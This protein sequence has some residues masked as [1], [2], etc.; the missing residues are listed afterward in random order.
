MNP[1]VLFCHSSS[2]G[3]LNITSNPPGRRRFGRPPSCSSSLELRRLLDLSTSRLSDRH[4]S[5]VDPYLV[6][7]DTHDSKINFKKFEQ[8]KI[9]VKEEDEEEADA[10]E[11]TDFKVKNDKGNNEEKGVEDQEDENSM[12]SSVESC[13]S[14]R[15]DTA[16]ASSGLASDTQLEGKRQR[17]LRSPAANFFATKYRLPRKRAGRRRGHANSYLSTEGLRDSAHIASS[18]G[19][20]ALFT[21]GQRRRSSGSSLKPLCAFGL[22]RRSRGRRS[23]YLLSSRGAF[24]R[25]ADNTY[26]YRRGVGRLGGLG[27]RIR[28]R[29]R[30]GSGLGLR[31]VG[32]EEDE[33]EDVEGMR[34]KPVSTGEDSES[35]GNISPID[36]EDESNEE[37]DA[38]GDGSTEADADGEDVEE[39]QE[40]ACAVGRLCRFPIRQSTGAGSVKWIACDHCEQWYH[41]LCVNI[42]HKSQVNVGIIILIFLN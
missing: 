40:E 16:R 9:S 15:V 24:N 20:P 25:E 38:E 42:K 41:Q 31:Y 22:G 30:G 32:P 3:S 39:A 35:E 28:R 17:R 14:D 1:V 33:E 27:I 13:Q 36:A 12:S 23:G 7:R 19:R 21:G 29:G 26:T 6:G 10:G 18:V 8:D 11:D 37:N 2:T 4:L 5:E 34:K